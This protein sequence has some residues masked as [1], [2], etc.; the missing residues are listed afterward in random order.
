MCGGP[1]NSAGKCF[2]RI[3]NDKEKSRKAGDSNKQHTKRKPP[4]CFRYG[5]EDHII[6]QCSKPTTDNKKWKKYVCF[7]ERDNRALKIK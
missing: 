4:K 7:S 6:A 1:K 2:K 3:R 5:S